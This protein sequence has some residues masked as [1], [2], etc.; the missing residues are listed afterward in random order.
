MTAA[1]WDG[2]ALRRLA[3]MPFLDRLELAAVTGMSE[4]TAHNVLDRLRGEG[5]ASCIRHAAPLTPSTRRWRLTTEGVRRLA[6]E[7]GTAV[8]SI[9]RTSPI[10][11][12]W[13]RV[14]LARLD[15]VAVIYRL[16]SAVAGAGGPPRFRWYRG[17][18]LDAAIMVPDGRTLG[19]IRQGATTDRTAFS[20]RVRWLPDPN[21]SLPRA[22]L[23]LLPDEVRL[24]QARRLLARYPGPVFLALEEHVANASAD[25]R[26]WRLTTTPAVLSLAEA[27]AHLRPGGRLPTE[28]PLARPSL[29][30]DLSIPLEP[31]KISDYLLPAVLKPAL[32]RMLDRLSEWPWITAEDLGGL[33]GLSESRVSA[34]CLELTRH[35]LLGRVSLDG[36]KRL[37]LGRR[38]LAVLARRDRTS[39]STAIQRWGAETLEDRAPVSWRNVPGARSRPLARTIEHTDAVH[40]FMAGLA[41]QA[42]RKLGYRVIQVSPP[43]RA[44]RYFRHGGRLRSVH[45]DGSGVVQAGERTYPFFLEWERRALNPSTMS[46]R[47]AP[48]LRYYSSNQP[49]DDH[50]HR[51][52][53]LLVFDDPLAEARF[54]T[55]ARREM[56]RTRV[57]L[58]LWVSHRQALERLGPLGPVWRNPNVLEPVY[59]FR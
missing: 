56:V 13:Q 24:R 54:H 29:P 48:Y 37:A 28:P 8:E 38:G 50:G 43:H 49:L 18:A 16:A 19:V 14:L 9:L 40:R 52:L 11:A 44:T 12:R 1:E 34:L 20:N 47:L 17:R 58:P 10:S 45:P 31:E 25:D 39:I 27:L 2:S 32:K 36:R 7:D 15:A 46:A 41:R 3:A 30:G 4:G 21:Q 35:G 6:L 22:L 51:P 33:M 42:R 5:L 59:A 55:V 53:M 57:S 23:V 26:V